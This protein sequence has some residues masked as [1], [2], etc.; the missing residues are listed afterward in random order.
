MRASIAIV[1]CA[2]HGSQPG[3]ERDPHSFAEPDHVAVR[4]LALDLTVDFAHKTL[5][6]TA[7]LTLARNDPK[8]REV[9]LDS[10]GLS[11]ERVT[12]CAKHEPR[13]FFLADRLS[14]GRALTV[15]LK[16][17]DA[18]IELAYRTSPDAGALL[19]VE[20]SGT[21]GGKP[22]LFTESQ[23]IL[24]RTWI[25]LQDTPSVRFTYE[26]TI[27]GTNGMWALMSAD[28]P[29]AAPPDGVWH[30]RQPR[31]IPSYLMALA[32][33]DFAF[34]A[35][36]PRSGVYAE[37][38]VVDAAAHEF[39]EVES[40]IDAAEKLYG[41]YRWGRYDM[42]V[43][44]PSFPFGGMENPNL[45]FLTPTVL[46]GDRALVSLIAHELA[47][48]WSGNLA[49]NSTWNDTW[50]NEGVTTY[51]EHRIMEE[52][53]GS[54][55]SDV[56]WFLS[57]KEI[58][59]AIAREGASSY[60]T[61][62]SHAFGRGTNPDDIPTALAYDKGALFLRTL[63]RS[64]GRAK[65]DAFLRGWFD[66]HAFAAVDSRMFEAEAKAQLGTKVDL[67]T[68]LYAPGLPADAA[69]ATSARATAIEKLAKQGGEPSA[70][71]WTTLDWVVFLR[72]LPQG[73]AL[74]RLQALDAR[75]HLT[76]TTNAEIA[77]HWLPL[78]VKAD[79]RDAAP[80]VQA[81]LL[82][83]GR[84]RMIRPLYD[85]MK[86]KNEFWH[87]LA[88]QTYERAKPRYHHLTREAIEK[89]LR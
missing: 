47:H 61:R 8:A 1:V 57:R 63:E 66:R 59:E 80:D 36:G 22:M 19:W 24:A 88:R 28:N 5:A 43:L 16:D 38:S 51:V 48:S 69:P 73:V 4:D 79:A 17:G 18:C 40:M 29:Q 25:P 86:D 49:T 12:D 15:H 39:A 7:K 67:K 58:D 2:C 10:D 14:I 55:F 44:P 68:W 60:K 81:Y 71:G 11:I 23:E 54:E 3:P 76:A 41:P 6:G 13:T 21:A 83:V 72:A 62:L 27:R 20:P 9:V 87:A 37:P 42:L 74:A 46:S 82:R 56:L 53:R 64:D 45:T 77:M 84:A 89:V 32:I 35:I 34:R 65:F 85:A 30:F 75:Y 50:L 33:G 52:L 31:A 70:D 78:L 26:A